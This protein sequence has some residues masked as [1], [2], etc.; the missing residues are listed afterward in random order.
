MD[1]TLVVHAA[2]PHPATRAI[3]SAHHRAHRPFVQQNV[4]IL[5]TEPSSPDLPYLT[6]QRSAPALQTVVSPADCV[7]NHWHLAGC[8]LTTHQQDSHIQHWL[9]TSNQNTC[10]TAAFTTELSSIRA[11]YCYSSSLQTW[12]FQSCQIL[13]YSMC[14]PLVLAAWKTV[15]YCLDQIHGV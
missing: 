7:A 2:A 10:L 8:H 15:S 3:C 4:V 11:Y 13:P 5:S 14:R 9:A 1:N 6:P 12:Y